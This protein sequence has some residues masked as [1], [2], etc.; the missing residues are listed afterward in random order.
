MRAAENL[1]CFKPGVLQDPKDRPQGEQA[2]EEVKGPYPQSPA[3]GRS[4]VPARAGLH[5]HARQLCGYPQHKNRHYVRV[6]GQDST[7][8][9]QDVSDALDRLWDP[10]GVYEGPE[11]TQAP[12][13]EYA[14]YA[15]EV[16]RQLRDGI[17][18]EALAAY[19]DRIAST[20]MGLRESAA[21]PAVLDS[22]AAAATRAAEDV[23]HWYETRGGR[24]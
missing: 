2:T 14:N 22:A 9:L 7:R 15:L 13:G 24:T 8:D 10:I 19:F 11:D 5:G 18:V 4:W 12:P 23:I 20:N 6:A 16:L 17:T 21:D 3:T 1:G